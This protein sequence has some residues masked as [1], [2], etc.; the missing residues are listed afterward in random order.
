M[1]FGAKANGKTD[2]ATAIQ[3]AIDACNA[4]GGGRV[5]IPAPHT[6][7]TGP[8]VLKSN[9]DFHVEA[10]AKVIANPDEKVYTKSAFRNNPGEGTMWISAEHIEN[11]IISGGGEINGNGISFMGAELD[12]SYDLKPFNILDPRPHVLTIIGGKNIQK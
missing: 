12:D 2:D 9:I 8:F 10:G 3:K 6:F 7:M 4:A 1:D 5:L 11:L